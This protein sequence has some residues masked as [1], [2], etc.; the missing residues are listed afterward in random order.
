M[1][2]KKQN[3][4]ITESKN[5]INNRPIDTKDFLFNHHPYL[6]NNHK[7]AERAYQRSQSFWDGS[8]NW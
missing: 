8:A 1:C 2:E 3:K 7:A 5:L 6:K 4:K